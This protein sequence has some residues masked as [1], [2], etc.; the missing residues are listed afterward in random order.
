VITC[1][2]PDLTVNCYYCDKIKL[3]AQEYRGTPAAYD[4]GSAAPRC[5]QHWRYLCAKCGT[6]AHFMAVSFCPK[7]KEFFCSTCATG[8]SEV[9]SAFWAWKYY[10][11]YQSPWSGLWVAALDRLEYEGKHPIQMADAQA[12]AHA[13]V[14][15][16]EFLIRYP[17]MPGQWDAE[18]EFTAPKSRPTGTGTRT[19]GTPGTTRTATQIVAI[20]VMSRCWRCWAT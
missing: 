3:S 10:F 16:E 7:A 19:G 17:Q 1:L 12:Q 14:S 6:P 9:E 2:T 15:R 13:A 5:A 11:R 18:R 8:Q 4:L 20:R